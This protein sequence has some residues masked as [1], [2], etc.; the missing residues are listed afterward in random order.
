MFQSPF[1]S[2]PIMPHGRTPV[3]SHRSSL[4]SQQYPSPCLATSRRVSPLLR[5]IATLRSS[6]GTAYYSVGTHGVGHSSHFASS[7]GQLPFLPALHAVFGDSVS[8]STLILVSFFSE[9]THHSCAFVVYLADCFFGR[10]FAIVKPYYVLCV[11]MTPCDTVTVQCVSRQQ[12]KRTLLGM[13]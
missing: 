12:V 6:P 4:F 11:Y 10:L 2:F 9:E 5:C 13:C 8:S 1:L 3:C 7:T